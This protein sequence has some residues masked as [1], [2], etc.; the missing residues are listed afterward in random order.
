MNVLETCPDCGV[1]LDKHKA[2]VTHAYLGAS[3]SCWRVYG[4]VLAREYSNRDFMK[5][6][7]WTV[8]AYAAQHPGKPE[9]RTIQSI[10]VHLL[11]LFLLVEKQ[12]EPTFVTAA[13]GKFIER[14]KQR[15]KWLAP[16][17]Q[18]GNVTVVDILSANT[19]EAHGTAVK[20]WAADVWNAWGEH[21]PTIR[22]LAAKIEGL[23]FPGS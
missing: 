14:E 3:G 8:D 6:H 15:F 21:H 4:E 18:R 22:N 9:P 5:F 16:P 20:K 7:R 11:A 12:S 19:V 17:R 23:E 10:N 1:K 13:M 2:D